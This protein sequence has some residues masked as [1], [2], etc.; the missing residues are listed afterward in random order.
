M[1]SMKSLYKNHTVYF[2]KNKTLISL[3]AILFF[4]SFAAS[5]FFFIQPLLYNFNWIA[6]FIVYA[7]VILLALIL[8]HFF[9]IS[10]KKN[11]YDQIL[12]SL[13]SNSRKIFIS[14]YLFLLSV[15]GVLSFLIAIILASF[16]FTVFTNNFYNLLYFLGIFISNFVVFNAFFWIFSLFS[17]FSKNLLYKNIV[18]VSLGILVT[19]PAILVRSLLAKDASDESLSQITKITEVS[20]ENKINNYYVSKNAYESANDSSKLRFDLINTLYFAPIMIF[21]KILAKN[22]D[23]SKFDS[24]RF[25]TYSI[26]NVIEKKKWNATSQYFAYDLNTKPLVSY[27]NGELLALLKREIYDKSDITQELIEKV[28]NT[29]NK[30]EWN[31]AVLPEQESNLI[32]LLSG[33]NNIIIRYIKRDWK[34]ILANNSQLQNLI[35]NTFG[36]AFWNLLNDFYNVYSF[37]TYLNVDIKGANFYFEKII[38]TN[39]EYDLASKIDD[40]D[41]EYLKNHFV[42]FSGDKVF[43]NNYKSSRFSINLTDFQKVFKSISSQKEWANFI[44]EN[45]FSL[46]KIND[47]L[48]NIYS[49]NNELH[50]IEKIRL[51]SNSSITKYY[52]DVLIP[53]LIS[54]SSL[55]FIYTFLVLL[56]IT[57]SIPFTTFKAIKGEI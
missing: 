40:I 22:Y 27:N 30:L 39:S 7:I 15:F 1:S 47:I 18:N 3:V 16:M 31:K 56:M 55:N 32:E 48:D 13:H 9:L 44:D 53:T 54:D 49:F 12:N 29:I 42:Q 35:I 28:R 37:N 14:K 8:N 24:D 6:Y 38:S 20:K 52:K 34:Y 43:F 36:L 4:S 46:Q 25:S 11:Q 5:P 57:I 33:K 2:F 51:L 23:V 45:A 19:I 26:K 21:N 17:S 50:N 41:K 10:T